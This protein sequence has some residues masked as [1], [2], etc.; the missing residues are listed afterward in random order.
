MRFLRATHLIITGSSKELLVNEIK[1]IVETFLRERGLELSI[2]KTKITNIKDGFDFLGQNIRKYKGKLIIKPAK[3]NTVNFLDKVRKI[4]KGN[5]QAKTVN[6]IGMLN[7][8]IRGWANYHCHVASKETFGKID[9]L[10]YKMVWQWAARRHPQKSSQWVMKKYF[11]SIENR[12]WVFGVKSPGKEEKLLL[13]Y[14]ASSTPI[15]RH[16]KILGEANPYDAEWE[17]YFEERIGLQMSSNLKQKHKLL[18][19]WFAQNGACPNCGQTITKQSGWNIHHVEYRV[20]GGSNRLD[21]L[22]LL[23][24]NCHRQVHTQDSSVVKAASC[25]KGVIKA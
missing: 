8:I 3:K 5:K 14:Q 9:H 12:K 23:H 11:L 16:M 6:L 18:R 15:N 21:N 13:L 20:N 22:I 1:P 4:I 17:R 2:E 25:D 24:P 10:I 7:P 19:L